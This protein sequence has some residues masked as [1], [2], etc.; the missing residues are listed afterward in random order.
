M[1]QKERV[2]APILESQLGVQIV[3]P[4][5]FNTDEFGTFTRT[6]QRP[7]DQ[8]TA[9]RLKAEAAIALTDSTLAFASEGSFGP[10]PSVPF[11]ACDCE[12]VLLIDRTH[13]LEIVGQALSTQTNYAHQTVTHLDAARKFAQRVG[14]PEHGLVAMSE[15]QP[16]PTSLVFKGITCE[17][18]LVT[19]VTDLLKQFGQAHLE[20]DM[21]AMHNPTRM[22]AIAQA[23]H[24]LVQKARQRCPQCSTPGFAPVRHNPGLPCALCGSPTLLALS[25]T[26]SCKKCGF[27]SL[28]YFPD[29][30]ETADPA[31][32]PFC[33]P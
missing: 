12:I 3:V 9:A 26:H 18:E 24:D 1:H 22:T 13:D 30:Q 27:S 10:H 8:L 33:N 6:V 32:C 21:R 5:D 2:I 16:S 7:G 25:V 20:T 29:G 17:A 23:T 14:F 28:S 15:A 11:L 4:Q 31:Q 19:I